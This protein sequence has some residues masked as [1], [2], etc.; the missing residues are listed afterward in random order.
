L[1]GLSELTTCLLVIAGCSAT[2][3]D[4]TPCQDHAECR[5]AFGFGSVCTSEGL[6]DQATLSARCNSSYPEDL[7]TRPAR[8]RD[9]V[10]LGALMDHSSAAHLVR[11]KAVRLAIKEVGEAGGLEGRPVGLIMCDIAQDSRIDTRSRTAAA[12]VAGEYLART[13]G[14]AAIIG[15]SASTDVQ[16]VWQTVAPLGT[17]VITPAASSAALTELE[18][19]STDERP[20]LLWRIA[21]PDSLQGR[22]IAEDM[23]ARNV[24]QVS[25][26][27]EN[28]A[29]GE[30]LADLFAA[31]FGK[32]G[33]LVQVV[34]VGSDSQIGSAAADAVSGR[35]AGS[36]AAQEVLFIS[37]Q[38]DWVIRFLNATGGL[39]SYSTEHLFL[40][41][42]AAN[43]SVFSG[44]ATA[45]ALFPRIRGTR[46][47]PR[48][49]DDYVYAAFVANYKAEYAGEDPAAATFSAHAYDATWLALFGAAWSLLR[50]GAV[51]GTGISRGLRHVSAGPPT[52]IIPA[53][54]PGVVAAFRG[55][56]Q[57]NVS[58]ASGELDF[59]PVTREASAPI[60]VWTVTSAAGQFTITRADS[61]RL[62]P[63]AHGP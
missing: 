11:E 17:V 61:G 32:G 40:T 18:P 39:P 14:T 4:Q 58:G 42:A 25:V 38:Q 45:A 57:V 23:L 6:C 56:A 55:G 28:G 30:G 46:P 44:A 1:R 20:G 50:E 8:Y 37:S 27:R 35:S 21:P 31:R 9:A 60:E 34:S 49:L 7:F 54:W 26:V 52:R 2:R 3:F 16:Q 48:G 51:S 10:V 19:V 22:V 24:R 15:P 5:E 43:L 47:A 53:S 12:V 33:G 41:D 62:S 13:L 59:D 63:D 29:Y 36:G